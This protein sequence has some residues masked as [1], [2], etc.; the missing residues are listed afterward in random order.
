MEAI[1]TVSVIDSAETRK[2]LPLVKGEGE[3]FAVLWPGNG[4]VLRSFHVIDL[5]SG[6]QTRDLSHRHECVYFVEAGGGAIVDLSDL[7][8]RPLVEGAMVHIGPNDVYRLEA[9]STG[10]RVIGGP[11]PVDP[12][13]YELAAEG[14]D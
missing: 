1:T 14:D 9:G 8:A 7:T 5:K 4:A 11:V 12:D 3:A 10:M 13:L 6:D 2:P